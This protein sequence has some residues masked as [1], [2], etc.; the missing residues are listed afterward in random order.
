MDFLT[1]LTVIV[2]SNAEKSR[3]VFL[4]GLLASRFDTISDKPAREYFM[5]LDT[6]IIMY[7]EFSAGEKSDIYDP[8]KLLSQI[9][10]KIREIQNKTRISKIPLIDEQK[11]DIDEL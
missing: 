3:L 7:T 5:L 1:Y 10:D 2:K 11:G 6:L 9:I 4:L 8:E